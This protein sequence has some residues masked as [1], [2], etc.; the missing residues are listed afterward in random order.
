MTE[1]CENCGEPI[2]QDEAQ[3]GQEPLDNLCQ[4]CQSI[5]QSAGVCAICVVLALLTIG[6]ACVWSFLPKLFEFFN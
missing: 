3:D 5:E 2:F 4:H 1:H 6:L